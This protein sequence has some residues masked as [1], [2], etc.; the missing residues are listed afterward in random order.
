MAR[1]PYALNKYATFTVK[2]Y[3]GDTN[4]CTIWWT[5]TA[6][7]RVW[8]L[9]KDGLKI[10]YESE[11]SQD[12]NSPI[13]ASKC[14][15][16]LMVTDGALQLF[17][18]QIRTQKNEKDVW[19]TIKNAG[20]LLW[21][22]YFI[23]DLEAQEDVSLPNETTLVAV[24]GI[25]T[26]KEVPFIREYT[27]GTTDAPTFPYTA[28][29]TYYNAGWQRLI[30]NTTSWLKLIVENTGQLLSSDSTSSTDLDDY[31]IQT[32]FNWWNEDM[33][34]SPDVANDPL[35]EM[36]IN[37]RNLYRKDENNL[38][39]PPSTYEVV[40]LICN[41]FNMRFFYWQHQFHF[42]GIGE[43]NTDEVGSAPYSSPINVP[44]RTYYYTGSNQLTENFVGNNNFSLYYAA[45]EPTLKSAGLQKIAGT[46]YQ[47]IPAIKKVN[48]FYKELAGS[49]YFN[50][51]P[52]F[53]THNSLQTPT[54]WPTDNAYHEFTQQSES[55]GILNEMRFT[56]AD[57]LA[58]WIVRI[59]A[60][61]TNTSTGALKMETAWSVRAKPATSNWGDSDNYVAY[62][63]QEP[64]YAEIRWQSIDGGNEFPLANNQQ[65]IRDYII[66]PANC[67][68]EIINI[69]DSSTTSTT[70][71]T[72]NLF[73]TNAAF[74]GDWDFQ[75]WTF[76]GYDNNATYP[77]QAQGNTALYSHG[78]IM[79]YYGLLGTSH[80]GVTPMVR[81]Q[82]PTTYYAFDYTDAIDMNGDFLS[83]FVPVMVNSQ[84]N[85]TSAQQIQ[86]NQDS[87]DTFTYEAGEIYFADG[88]GANSTATIQVWNGSAWVF[89][90]ALGKWGLA[91]HTYDTGT[92]SWTWTVSYNKKLQDLLGE[93]IL[94]NQSKSLV[95]LN[96]TTV[97]SETE[98]YYTGSTKRKYVNP[99]ARLVDADGKKYMMMRSTFNMVTDEW[100]GEWVQMSRTVP[101]LT[102]NTQTWDDDIPDDPIIAM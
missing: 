67:T 75:F 71:T 17:L 89:V 24:D 16:N 77:L 23:L 35:R 30:G 50:G 93:E 8:T 80:L 28:N 14:T 46:I 62:K 33:D 102:V 9:A 72:G 7:T 27:V 74:I 98:K 79:N 31:F 42:I 3:N 92:A 87:S 59:Y 53:V 94:N 96:G 68:N 65:Y 18:N 37:I 48:I 1:P 84:T 6:N 73:P 22:G 19:I 100:S 36:R 10:S 81:A 13:L 25:A 20:Q 38:F 45:I 70:N 99:V 29:D 78:R 76:S 91:E 39:T 82:T 47:A 56:D 101:T 41:N 58:G 69:W 4:N 51:Y 64:T 85:A 63:H 5:G 55:N 88:S 11:K 90:D 54:T 15:I 66:I 61:F 49:N 44:S 83:R 86:V 60:S 52:L 57:Q 95:T 43:Y 97:L 34:V 21:A 26:L 2:S 40:K 32:A 12:K